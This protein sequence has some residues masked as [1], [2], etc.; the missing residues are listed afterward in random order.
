MKLERVVMLNICIIGVTLLVASLLIFSKRLKTSSSWQ[1]T[2]TPLASIMGS[3]FL[4][5]APL[6]AGEVGN[7]AL[8]CMAI[9][10]CLAYG[11]GAVIRFNIRYFEPIENAALGV[12]QIVGGISKIVLAGAYFISVTYYLQLFAAFFLNLI[13]HSDPLY[14]KEV[15]TV[16]LVSIGGVGM[17]R[18][19]G[20]LEKLETYAVGFNL[21]MISA[22]LLALLFYNAKLLWS[23]GWNLPVLQSHF[24]MHSLRVLLGLLIVVQGFE[25][26]RYL[27]EKH[28]AEQRIATMRAAQLISGTIYL[29]FIALVTVLFADGLATDVTAIITMTAPV[30]VI[31]PVLLSVAALGSQFSAAVADTVGAGGLLEDVTRQKLPVRYAYLL[32]LLLTVALTWITDV[33]EII[34]YAS[35]A[36]ALFYFFQA[37]ITFSV[38]FT[39]REVPKRLRVLVGSGIIALV[40]LAVVLFGLPVE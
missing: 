4:I 12:P 14:A 35:R 30:A 22:F 5:S 1:A 37:V 2:V 27:G 23:G 7:F 10:L 32:I 36:F 24:T 3:G 39:K 25:T 20:L 34:A 8:V 19:L 38:A 15:T 16:L 18:G 13:G 28:S 17:W 40:C 21:G 11:V 33:E 31:L 26:S 9:L 6:L 29:V